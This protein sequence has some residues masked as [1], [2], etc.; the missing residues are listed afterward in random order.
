MT[1]QIERYPEFKTDQPE[2]FFTLEQLSRTDPENYIALHTTAPNKIP[3]VQPDAVTMEFERAQ[4]SA[5]HGDSYEIPPIDDGFSHLFPVRFL[6]L[7]HYESATADYSGDIIASPM[8]LAQTVEGAAMLARQLQAAKPNL[9]MSDKGYD[10]AM[11]NMKTQGDYALAMLATHQIEQGD[12]IHAKT[13]AESISD[14]SLKLYMLSKIENHDVIHDGTAE[15]QVVDEITEL[16]A[17][18]GKASV[19]E[20]TPDKLLA[21]NEAAVVLGNKALAQSAQTAYQDR[22]IASTT[23]EHFYNATHH[24]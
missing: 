16:T 23:F 15:Q 3:R 17:K 4:T 12:G 13:L 6:D 5:S 8:I 18:L 10:G 20:T 7:E 9:A 24:S 19:T 2:T 21:L 22:F 1:V 14:D 11:Q